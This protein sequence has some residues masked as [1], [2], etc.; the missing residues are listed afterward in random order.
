MT[1]SRL[2]TIII[3]VALLLV[4]FTSVVSAQE[5]AQIKC[6]SLFGC[7]YTV[8]YTGGSR[9]GFVGTQIYPEKATPT[10]GRWVAVE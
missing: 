7:R 8:R 2:A 6:K 3:L 4:A 5:P 1:R 10:S 9:Y